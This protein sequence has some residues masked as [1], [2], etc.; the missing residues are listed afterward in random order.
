LDFDENDE[1]PALR[2]MLRVRLAEDGGRANG[3]SNGLRVA[4]LVPQTNGDITYNDGPIGG[5]LDGELGPGEVGEILIFPLVP[6][7]WPMSRD[8]TGCDLVMMDGSRV[9]G[10]A[11]VL[12]RTTASSKELETP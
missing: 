4:W 7:L 5:L 11:H 6:G 10:I 12:G 2:A 1:W 8:W 9:I 3:V